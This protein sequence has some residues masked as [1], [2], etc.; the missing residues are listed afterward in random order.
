MDPTRPAIGITGLYGY[1]PSR[2]ISTADLVAQGHLTPAQHARYGIDSLPVAADHEHASDLMI[3]AARRLLGRLALPPAEIGSI[4]T[5]S[6]VPPEYGVWLRAAKVAHALGATHATGFDLSQG[7]NGF[8]CALETAVAQLTTRPGLRH[9]L[10]TAGDRWGEYTRHRKAAGVLWGDAGAAAVV[11]VGETTRVPLAFAS[12]MDAALH[13]VAYTDTG[14]PAAAA[15]GETREPSYRIRDHRRLTDALLPQ[16]TDRFRTV[17]ASA[18]RRAGVGWDGL[19]ALYLQAGR[20]DLMR[21]HIEALGFDAARTNLAH[22]PQ[23]G[24]L[25]SAAPVVSLARLLEEPCLKAGGTVL[26]L[27]QG[28]GTVWSAMVLRHSP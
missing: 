5:V 24:D 4:L 14:G 21:R 26:A 19:D 7:C 23:Q 3:T 18:L 2:R 12:T 9:V 8:H 13:D 25:S 10:I 22:L 1:L 28:T 20:V 16:N 6:A 11:S 27:T 15:G 17:A